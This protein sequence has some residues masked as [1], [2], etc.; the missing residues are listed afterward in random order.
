MYSKD[1]DLQFVASD[2]AQYLQPILQNNLRKMAEDSGW[3]VNIVSSLSVDFDG[4]RLSVRYPDSMSN[5]VD[6]LEYG[7]P[8]GLP[9]PVIRPFKYRSEGVIQSALLERTLDLILDVEGMF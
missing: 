2:A 5:E 7:K 6:D 4:E 3:P 9:N 1:R 8:Y